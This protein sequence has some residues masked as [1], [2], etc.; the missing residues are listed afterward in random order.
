MGFRWSTREKALELGLTGWVRNLDDGCVEVWIEGASERVESMVAWL[1]RGPSYAVVERT[2]L[3]DSEP[4]GH[5]E[6]Q[7]R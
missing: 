7:V 5:R 4:A 2:E 6:F 1:K 3:G